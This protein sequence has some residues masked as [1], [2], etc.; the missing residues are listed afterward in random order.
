M[1]AILLAAGEGRRLRP[2]TRRL[3]KVLLP[4][5][6]KPLLAHW[7]DNCQRNGVREVLVNG[8]YQ[9]ACLERFI[10]RA[11]RRYRL[12]IHLVHEETLLGTGGTARQNLDFVRGEDAFLLCHGDNYTDIDLR[13]L[14]RFHRARGA[15]LTVAL[16][17]TDRPG[18]CGIVEAMDPDGRIRA[19][20]EKPAATHSNLASAAIFCLSPE[21]VAGLPARRHSDFS[22]DVLPRYQGRMYGFPIRGVNVDIG[23]LDNFRRANR[24]ASGREPGGGGRTEPEPGPASVPAVPGSDCNRLQQGKM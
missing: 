21:V 24:I 13:A 18:Q 23:T 19:F 7:L 2:L 3:P 17:R 10:Q 12:R 1:K 5:N 14:W 11:R 16:F 15:P 8:H 20:V 9:W 6:G 22:R 4:V